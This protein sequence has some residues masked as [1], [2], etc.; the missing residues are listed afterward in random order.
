M[1]LAGKR[2][3]H[4]ALCHAARLDQEVEVD[5]GADPHAVQH[6]DEVL[7][8]KMARCRGRVR[9]AAEASDRRVEV[10]YAELESDERVHERRSA[11]VVKVQGQLF[12]RDLGEKALHDAPRLE[13]GSDPDRVTE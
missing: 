7:R 4:D 6:V 11:R 8:G 2:A 12:G 5:A 1:D 10:S 3:A 9:A 13:R